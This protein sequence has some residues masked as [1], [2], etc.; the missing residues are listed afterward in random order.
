MLL[1]ITGQKK[2]MDNSPFLQRSIA[3]RKPSIDPVNYIQVILLK[4]LRHGKTDGNER[5]K[6]IATLMMSINCIAAGLRNTG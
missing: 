1:K 2:I 6:L 3:M 4:R 5:E